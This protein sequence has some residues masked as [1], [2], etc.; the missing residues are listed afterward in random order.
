MLTRLMLNVITSFLCGQQQCGPHFS[1][2]HPDLV[3]RSFLFIGTKIRNNYEL[4]NFS[5]LVY[6][7]T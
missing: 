1:W 4:S 3:L 6:I 5:G 7:Y 2:E